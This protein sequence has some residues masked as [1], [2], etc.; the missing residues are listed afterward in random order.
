MSS[1]LPWVKPLAKFAI[2][3]NC[4]PRGIEA[5]EEGPRMASAGFELS[6]RSV[7]RPNP[8]GIV[9]ISIVSVRKQ[10]LMPN[11]SLD[12]VQKQLLCALGI[13][14]S[15]SAQ[16]RSV[17]KP[18]SPTNCF[19]VARKSTVGQSL[20]IQMLTN[21]PWVKPLAKY[22]ISSNCEPRRIEAEE[23]GP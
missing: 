3:F 13:R 23:D 1:H 8:R 9:S 6:L 16:W 7:R 18:T 21:L 15:K 4:E 5:E 20:G 19:A 22:T 2:S 12:I 11:G 10:P 17:W 14:S